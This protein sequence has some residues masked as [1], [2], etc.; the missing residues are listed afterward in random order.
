MN[1]SSQ[2]SSLALS[3]R[4]KEL[5]V[6]QGS[7]FVWFRGHPDERHPLTLGLWSGGVSAFEEYAAFTVAE[8]GEMLPGTIDPEPP[9]T[10]YWL[11]SWAITDKGKTALW[12]VAYEEDRQE[13]CVAEEKTE[14]DARAKMLIHLLENKIISV[15]SV[16]KGREGK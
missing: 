5:G 8:L 14:A 13:F 7:L 12:G 4:L 16:N 11:N 2:V 3:K 9:G 10:C 1:L 6:K 15:D